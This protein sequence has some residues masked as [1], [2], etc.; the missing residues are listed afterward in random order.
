MY[1]GSATALMRAGTFNLPP[2]LALCRAW[3]GVRGAAPA[4]KAAERAIDVRKNLVF[5]V[6]V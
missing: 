3:A 4:A 5:I 2:A 6:I 1:T